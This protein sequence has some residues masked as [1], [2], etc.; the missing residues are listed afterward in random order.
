MWP[1]VLFAREAYFFGATSTTDTPS[2][3]HSSTTH[4]DRL[5]FAPFGEVGCE[6]TSTAPTTG[7]CSCAQTYTGGDGYDGY[8][9]SLTRRV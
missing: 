6:S 3:Y 2:G 5:A 8:I 9:V 1:F 4:V 7:D